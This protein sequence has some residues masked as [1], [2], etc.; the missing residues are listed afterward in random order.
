[1]VNFTLR[2]NS[3]R[4]CLPTK[5]TGLSVYVAYYV[6]RF[7]KILAFIIRFTVCSENAEPENG[8]TKQ[9]QTLENTV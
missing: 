6:V 4:L 9:I 2:V 8:G 1:L 7:G 3:R 5:E